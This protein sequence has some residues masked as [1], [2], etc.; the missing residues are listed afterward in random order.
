M[1]TR[2]LGLLTAVAAVAATL[3]LQ[4]AHAVAPA[5]TESTLTLED[6]VPADAQY[7]LYDGST[8][9]VKESANIVELTT[10]HDGSL[11][12]T[13]DDTY[14]ANG[15]LHER[16]VLR[17]LKGHQLRVLDDLFIPLESPDTIYASSP[18]ISPDNSTVVWSQITQSG[19]GDPTY[20]LHTAP[21]AAGAATVLPG[22]KDLAFASYL[23]DTTLLAMDE[24]LDPT[25]DPNAGNLVSLPAAGGAATS[26]SS[27]VAANGFTVSHDGTRVAWSAATSTGTGAYSAALQ[28][29]SFTDASGTVTLGTIHTLASSG[30]NVSPAWSYDDS[31]IRF[32]NTDGGADSPGDVWTVS[33]D[34]TS[35]VA[36][37]PVATTQQD[38]LAVATGFADS[39]APA[40]ST[41]NPFTL[42]GT[43]VGLSW[44][45][46][47]DADVA[48]VIISRS[49][50]AL[51]IFVAAPATS[52]TV[53]NLPLNAVF[54][55]TFTTVDRSGNSAGSSPAASRSVTALKPSPSFT[56]PTS[57]RA[58]T[59]P[60]SVVFGTGL[61]STT[62]FTV[63]YSAN[64]G[65]F[66][67]W[68]PG[69]TG[70]KRPFGLASSGAAVTT[71]V[72]GSS[73]RFRITVTDAYGNSGSTLM[74]G[75]AV[76]PYDQNR[77]TFSKGAYTYRAA[78]RWLG[79]VAVLP[80]TGISAR[81][82]LTGN[83]LQVIGDRCP[84]CGVV[85]I[86]VGTTKVGAVDTYSRSRVVRSVLFTQTYPTT[87][88]RTIT[89]RAR[90]TA[91]RPTVI[92]DGYAMRR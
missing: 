26:V 11:V 69:L 70:A 6:S 75:T 71:S 40:A 68:I 22:G 8:A 4:A 83:R 31:A 52:Y 89:L 14:T 85:D 43:S 35:S 91:H 88:P 76:V 50:A 58:A 46:P 12:V 1:I 49:P 53:T 48:G 18:S 60:F 36:A 3:P 16:V 90:G 47:A 24:Q 73:Y 32:I 38:E 55:Y 13:V 82:T 7:G 59:A 78:D 81:V 27:T 19:T 65:A 28:E 39:V 92:L 20:E 9:L 30:N 77:A 5:G 41:A 23:N 44:T 34:P 33:S 80:S 25:A 57:A 63:D 21:V 42:N 37:A 45:L 56:D 67:N 86:Y 64:G 87:G 74:T 15:D 79:A 54:T 72:P 29:A 2:R 51:P 10:S 62:R 66:R 17:D 61:P 84:S